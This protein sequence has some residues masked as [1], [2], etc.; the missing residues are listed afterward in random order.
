MA[1]YIYMTYNDRIVSWYTCSL[2]MCIAA[3]SAP[4]FVAGL[5][6]NTG[7]GFLLCDGFDLL[8]AEG[9]ITCV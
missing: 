5:G 2:E 1:D 9:K 8:T 6:Y 7:D 4:S 3:S